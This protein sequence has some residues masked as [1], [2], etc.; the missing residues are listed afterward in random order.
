MNCLFLVLPTMPMKRQLFVP[1]CSV[2]IVD[3]GNM[4]VVDAGNMIDV[5]SNNPVN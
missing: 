3:A 1:V 5:N 4:N 2:E